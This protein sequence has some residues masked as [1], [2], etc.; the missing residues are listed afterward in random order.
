[1][2]NR[3]TIPPRLSVVKT[4]LLAG[5]ACLASLAH[6]STFWNGANT[7]Y[8]EPSVGASDVLVATKVALARNQ[9]SYLYNSVSET[10]AGA[11]SPADTLWAIASPSVVGNLSPSTVSGLSFITFG[12]VR[13]MA[14]SEFPTD[15]DHLK[16][17]LTQNPGGNPTFVVHLINEDTYLTLTFSEWGSGFSGG[18]SYARSTPS[19]V[20]TPPTPSVSI[21]NPAPNAVFAAPANVHIGASASVSS[22][23]VSNVSFFGNGSLLGSS[24]ASPFSIT[25]NSLA[26][27]PYALTA[28]ATAAGVS[29]TSSVVNISVVTP[30]TTLLSNA[31]ATANNQFVF[32]YNVNPGLSYVVEDSGDLSSFSP[33]ATNV[34]SSSPAFFTNPISGNQNFFRVGRMPNP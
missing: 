25:A 15:I 7:N 27:G 28:V 16:V 22:G 19:A 26:A 5:V 24:Q 31:T 30:V 14:M 8:T 12:A 23:V 17:F 3:L 1:M 11:N 13:S 6:G 18:F 20:V 2:K 9:S 29:A 4:L 10:F 33:L 32:S 21:T 34:P